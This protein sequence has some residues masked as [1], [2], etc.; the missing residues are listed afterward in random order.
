MLKQFSIYLL[1]SIVVVIFAKYAQVI[2]I[3]I[4]ALFTFINLQL[5]PIFNQSEMGVI[6]R[7][8]IVLMLLPLIIISIPALAYRLAKGQ[9]MPYLIPVTWMVWTVIVLSDILLS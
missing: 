2:I 6:T 4:D 8:I 3:N 1:L 7:K 5:S 9:T